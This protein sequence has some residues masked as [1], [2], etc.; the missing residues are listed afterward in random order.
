MAPVKQVL[1]DVKV[2]P[3]RID[4]VVLV[5]GSTRIPKIRAD[6]EAFFGKAPSAS[7]HPDEAVAYGAAVQAALITGVGSKVS[8]DS[9]CFQF[10]LPN[11]LPSLILS[12][13]PHPPPPPP[14]RS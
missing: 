6:I 4:E 13:L 9:P 5:G 2:P 12:P 7:V 10:S 14:S 1:A 8:G 3:S 11:A